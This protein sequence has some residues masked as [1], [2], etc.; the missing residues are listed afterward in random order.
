METPRKI[1]RVL[2]GGGIDDADAFERNV[3]A[4][5]EVFDSRGVA[6]HDGRAQPQRQEL[7]RRLQNAR[8]LAFRKHDPL[9]MPLQF[10]DDIADETHGGRLTA[11][12]ETA[13]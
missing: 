8:I 4:F 5:R 9:G 10:F 2:A 12:R 13:K 7:P 3:H 11:K 6:Q 1:I